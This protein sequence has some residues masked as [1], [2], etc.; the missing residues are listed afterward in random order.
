MVKSGAPGKDC[1]AFFQ[2]A[3]TVA[4]SVN[5]L[6]G[7]VTGGL[8]FPEGQPVSSGGFEQGGNFMKQNLI[9]RMIHILSEMVGRVR[10]PM[11]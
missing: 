4:E 10:R 8:K 7:D 3:K 11:E 9:H 2:C 1:S 5:F 6:G